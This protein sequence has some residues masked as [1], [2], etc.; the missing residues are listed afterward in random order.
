MAPRSSILMVLIPVHN[1]VNCRCSSFQIIDC[2]QCQAES[3]LLEDSKNPLHATPLARLSQCCLLTN[4]PKECQNEY[5]NASILTCMITVATVFAF[6]VCSNGL[7]TAAPLRQSSAIGLLLS[8]PSFCA[9]QG[10]C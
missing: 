1:L 9:A 7:A 6:K 2:E 10:Y 8:T 3:C 4:Q 5:E